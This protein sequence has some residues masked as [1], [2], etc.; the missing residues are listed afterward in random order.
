MEV[1]GPAFVSSTITYLLLG[2]FETVKKYD[3]EASSLCDS[4]GDPLD[5]VKKEN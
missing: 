2:R 3:D 1:S 5:H 4:I